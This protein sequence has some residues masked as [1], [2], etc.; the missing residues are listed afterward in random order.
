MGQRGEISQQR[1]LT[2]RTHPEDGVVL[3]AEAVGILD[4][5]LGFAD[6]SQTAESVRWDLRRLPLVGKS[7]VQMPEDLFS[8]GEEEIAPIRDVPERHAGCRVLAS[9]VLFGK[10][11]LFLKQAQFFRRHVKELAKP[12]QIK[13][14]GRGHPPLPARDIE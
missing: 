12:L 1:L 8:P 13:S 14:A 9:F 6:A 10:D 4:G 11:V 2:G 5:E 7:L 3:L